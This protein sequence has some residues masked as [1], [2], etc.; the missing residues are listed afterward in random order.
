[1]K[2]LEVQL[3]GSTDW[4]IVDEMS[5]FLTLH[6][7]SGRRLKGTQNA[8]DTDLV[9][10]TFGC[11]TVSVK[12]RAERLKS[13]RHT[14][15]NYYYLNWGQGMKSQGMKFFPSKPASTKSYRKREDY[16]GRPLYRHPYR[17]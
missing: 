16:L 5:H 12:A 10:A 7:T 4:Q 8:V 9:A 17:K 3:K 14:I 13:R 6:Q 11:P 15:Q 1:M 2:S